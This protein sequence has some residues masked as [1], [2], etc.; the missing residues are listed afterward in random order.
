[1]RYEPIDP[2]SREEAER[3][4]TTA[5]KDVLVRVILGVALNDDDWAWAETF[6]LRFARH[7]DPNIR[8]I[9]LLILGHLAR[10]FRVL[11]EGRVRPPLEAGLT[12]PDPYVRGHAESAT[13]DVES[14]LG[15]RLRGPHEADGLFDR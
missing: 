15:W 9:A 8:G 13:D 10:R 4:A 3:A 6:C 5:P 2:V 12:D 11:D 1:V 7:P 14:Y